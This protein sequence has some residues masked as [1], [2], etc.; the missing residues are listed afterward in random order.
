VNL[1]ERFWQARLVCPGGGEYVWNEQ[2][3]T[4][5]STV[6]GSPA[7]PKQ[8]NVAP[9]PLEQLRRANFGL[10]FEE[11][12]LRARVELEREAKR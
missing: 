2:Y 3:Q 8:A 11:Q 7:T 5:E 12:G 9:A 4:M 10:T 1:H 6:F